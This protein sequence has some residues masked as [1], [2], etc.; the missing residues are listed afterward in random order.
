MDYFVKRKYACFLIF[1]ANSLS[2]IFIFT[3]RK[4]TSYVE[5]A[6]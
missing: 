4:K 3:Q 1:T 5:K 2:E 6:T